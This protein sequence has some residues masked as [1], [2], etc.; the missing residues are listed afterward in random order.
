MNASVTSWC[1]ELLQFPDAACFRVYERAKRDQWQIDRAVDWG[2]M[3]L[4]DLPPSVRRSMAMLYTQIQYGEMF[5]LTQ[6][7]RAVSVAPYAWS[8]LIGAT[9]VADEA[10]HVE[11]FS[12]VVHDLGYEFPVHDDLRLFCEEVAACDS[13]EEAF[14]GTQLLLESYALSVFLE[15]TALA[16]RALSKAIRLVSQRNVLTFLETVGAYV[17]RDEARHVAFGVMFMRE[18]WQ[19]LSPKARDRLQ[20]RA[21]QWSVALER[22]MRELSVE[23]GRLG[24]DVEQLAERVRRRREAHFADIG[25]EGYQHSADATQ[26]NDIDAVTP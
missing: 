13:A 16:R 3:G 21:E 18:H 15:G 23:L 1:N 17:G 2:A 8:R 9:Q 10:R 14:L 20:L 24:V 22:H 11:F 19:Q 12:R 7:A 26:A 6:S 5:A 4:T 25:F